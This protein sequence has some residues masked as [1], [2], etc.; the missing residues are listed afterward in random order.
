M[1]AASHGKNQG[2][3][4]SKSQST[5]RQRL[6]SESTTQPSGGRSTRNTGQAPTQNSNRGGR[7][8]KLQANMKLDAQTKEL[9]EFRRQALGT[10]TTSTRAGM[11]PQ[12]QQ[13][14]PVGT[15]LSARLRANVADEEWQ[16][17]PEEWLT[18]QEGTPGESSVKEGAAQSFGTRAKL[19]LK[20]GLASDEESIS[21][22]TE[23]SEDQ[24]EKNAEVK[25]DYLEYTPALTPRPSLVD[26]RGEPEKPNPEG[27]IEWETVSVF[28]DIRTH[29]SLLSTDMRYIA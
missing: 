3:A 13:R 23:L 21:D 28:V 2:R 12:I 10:N 1:G 8:A 17:V 9:A 6:Q 22:L 18:G 16:P 14:R 20:T 15:R 29:Q 4:S 7:A 26:D 24:D 19:L 25:S 5:K 11:R 27:F